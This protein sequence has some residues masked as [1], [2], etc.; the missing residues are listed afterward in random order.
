MPAYRTHIRIN[1]LLMLPLS[2]AALKYTVKMTPLDLISFST[3]FIYGTFFLHP[4]L[5]LA[6]NIRLFSLKGILTLPF[7]P[8]SYLLKHRGISHALVLGTFI[9]LFW[10]FSLWIFFSTILQWHYPS[11]NVFQ[12][13]LV[14][15]GIGGLGIAD[16]SHILLDK[17]F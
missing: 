13:P 8:L 14:W 5:D 1:L 17:L 12:N 2:L 15:F 6:R 11:V 16:F 4:D 9:R 10:L 3:C 7:R